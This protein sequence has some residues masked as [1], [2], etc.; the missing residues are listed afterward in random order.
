MSTDSTS[1]ECF[2]EPIKANAA[3]HFKELYLLYGV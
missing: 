2:D 1:E 3:T